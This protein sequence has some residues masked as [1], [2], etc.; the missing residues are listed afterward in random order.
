MENGNLAV[1]RSISE[2]GSLLLPWQVKGHGQP[3]LS[4][5][6]LVER[7]EAY[8][9][10]LELAR[11]TVSH[12]CNQMA[13]WQLIGM[14][15]PKGTSARVSEAV[16]QFGHAAVNQENQEVCSQSAQRAIEHALDASNLLAAAYVDQSM[17]V[18]RRIGKLLSFVAGDLGNTL[19]DERTAKQ[20]LNTFNAAVLPLRWRDIES[21][22][23]AHSW[24]VPDKQVAWC[25][26]QD[27]KVFSGP[28]LQLDAQGIPNWLYLWEEDFEN[29]ESFTNDFV[30]KVVKR[31]QGKVDFWQ[32]AARVNGTEVLSLSEDECLQLTARVVELIRSLDPEKPV[33]MSI[34]QPWAEYMR[35]R[36]VDYPPLH[37]ADTLIRSGLE[38]AGVVL[39]MNLGYTPGGTLPRT[40]MELSRQ[41][42]MWALLGLPVFVSLTVPSSSEPDSLAQRQPQ[43]LPEKPTVQSQQGWVAR[44][45]PLILAKSYVRGVIWN[46]LSDGVPHDFPHGGLFDAQ[47]RPKPAIKTLGAIRHAYLK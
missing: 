47:A 13:E 32:A 17:A 34:D 16:R 12:L 3:I 28:L 8:Y 45:V 42:D 38:I 39:E 2:S 25:Q 24:S 19:L 9:L 26:S 37:F 14:T 31:Y 41:L 18:R 23:G 20:F 36:T 7:R 30:T 22:E 4:T 6:S 29:L 43:F 21:T 27:L 1:E 15:V 40:L 5:A 11:G 44:T 35:S 33:L 10:P 46:Q